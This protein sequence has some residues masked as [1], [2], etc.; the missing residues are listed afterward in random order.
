M[1][2]YAGDGNDAADMDEADWNETFTRIEDARAFFDNAREE[3]RD[4]QQAQEFFHFR[5]D[6]DE[7]DGDYVAYEQF[8]INA[9]DAW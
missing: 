4:A 9:E 2:A 5:I 6:M 8:G 7:I 1:S 3:N